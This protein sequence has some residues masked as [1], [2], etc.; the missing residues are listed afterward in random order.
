M[1]LQKYRFIALVFIIFRNMVLEVVNI[2]QIMSSV[3]KYRWVACYIPRRTT[4][5]PPPCPEGERREGRGR[6]RGAKELILV[7]NLSYNSVKL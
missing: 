1:N 7:Y 4:A 3:F 2:A 5:P 6:S